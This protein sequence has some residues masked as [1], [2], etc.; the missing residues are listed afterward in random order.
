MSGLLKGALDFVKKRFDEALCSS[1]NELIGWDRA[2]IKPHP[3]STT[4]HKEGI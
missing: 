4:L 3:Q 1:V 2:V